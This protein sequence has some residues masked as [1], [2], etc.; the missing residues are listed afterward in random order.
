MF[1]CKYLLNGD[2]QLYSKKCVAECEQYNKCSNCH[3][4]LRSA[5]SEP[6]GSCEVTRDKKEG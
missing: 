2:C 6:C 1:K 4:K 5:K 3:Y